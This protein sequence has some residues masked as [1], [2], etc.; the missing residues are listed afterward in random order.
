MAEATRQI[1]FPKLSPIWPPKG[2]KKT[3]DER[4]TRRGAFAGVPTADVPTTGQ[5]IAT[6][7]AQAS[8]IQELRSQVTNSQQE[9]KELRAQLAE[10]IGL[11]RSAGAPIR[12]AEPRVPSPGDDDFDPSQPR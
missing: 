1:A 8:Q 9:T 12:P 11:L 10:V 4:L 2:L 3:R 7:N 5:G 6:V